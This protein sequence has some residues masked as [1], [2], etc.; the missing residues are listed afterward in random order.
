MKSYLVDQSIFYVVIIYVDN[1]F[2]I[3]IHSFRTRNRRFL[4]LLEFSEKQSLR[5][6]LLN[7]IHLGVFPGIV[8]GPP[9]CVSVCLIP[10]RVIAYGTVFT[11]CDGDF[12]SLAFRILLFQNNSTRFVAAWDQLSPNAGIKIDAPLEF[13]SPGFLPGL[14]KA[15]F[16]VTWFTTITAN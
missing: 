10:C 12:T 3:H 11:F 2:I 6:K 1:M 5:L 9:V 7:Q 14:L 8:E 4:V 13:L 15:N 16:V